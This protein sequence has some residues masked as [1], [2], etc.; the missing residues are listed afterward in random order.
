[1]S[2]TDWFNDSTQKKSQIKKSVKLTCVYLPYVQKTT[3][4]PHYYCQ[5]KYQITLV[6]VPNYHRWKAK[7]YSQLDP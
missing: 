5:L 7:A 6:L 2:Y 1:M 4:L 3:R